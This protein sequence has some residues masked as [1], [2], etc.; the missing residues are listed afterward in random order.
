MASYIHFFIKFGAWRENFSVN[1]PRSTKQ[2]HYAQIAL[3]E[4]ESDG[5]LPSAPFHVELRSV[6]I[7]VV[8]LATWLCPNRSIPLRFI[9][10]LLL[11]KCSCASP[12]MNVHLLRI[13]W[14]LGSA[15]HY[16]MPIPPPA[17][18]AGVS[19]LML[20]TKDSV[21]SRVDATL[22]AFCS[23]LLVTFAGSRIPALIISTYSSL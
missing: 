7:Y 23:A 20:A 12:Q 3:H 8:E 5:K 16:I 13:P 9:S 6:V 4:R 2:A 17:G 19:S 21:V 11:A 10:L 22:V 15:L 1:A 18:I 14:P